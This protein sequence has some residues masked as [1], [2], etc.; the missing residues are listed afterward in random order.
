MVWCSRRHGTSSCSGFVSRKLLQETGS[1]SLL[2]SV[3]SSNWGRDKVR[4]M[5]PF[6]P[7]K[8]RTL[9]DFQALRSQV[10]VM[11]VL[12]LVGWKS[13]SGHGNQLRG[14]CPVHKSTNSTSRSFAVH[15]EKNA[16]HCFGCGSQGNQ[17]DLASALF[18]KEL[19]A[20][21]RE[22]CHRL[23]IEPPVRER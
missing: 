12:A 19:Y 3:L 10:S 8:N 15:T 2:N 14:P 9:I 21:A 18:G 23:G 22:L 5:A 17:L 20:T 6:E 1:S 7:Q 13:T 16:Y 4:V 11:D